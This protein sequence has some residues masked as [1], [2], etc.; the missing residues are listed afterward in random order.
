MRMLLAVFALALAA[1][2]W[3]ETAR[4]DRTEARVYVFGNSL[5][6]HVSDA[7]DPTNVPHWMNEMAKADG[8]GLSLDGQWGFLRDFADNLPPRPNWSFSGVSGA[9]SPSQGAFRDA[10]I[11]AVVLTPANFIQYQL[12]D[13]PY[14]G[15]NPTGESPLGALQRVFD[16]VE[17]NSPSSR[18]FIYEGW[19]TMDG[20]VNRFPPTDREAEAYHAHNAGEY[21][22]WYRD[23]L[24]VLEVT[25][26]DMRVTLIPVA[27][28]LAEL[29]GDGG[30]LDSL[31]A[32]ALYTDDAPHGTPTLYLLAA[33][34]TYA[35]L[36]EAP[37]PADFRPP[38]TLHP[39]VLDR[40][41]ELAAAIWERVP[42]QNAAQSVVEREIASSP[43]LP[44][45]E[46]IALPPSGMVPQGAPAL[47][48][49]LYGIS[50]WSTQHPFL[51]LMKSSR[52][53][54]GNA[55]NT[56][57]TL[58]TDE[59]RAGGYLDEND[60]PLRIPE[61]VDRIVTV[62]LTDQPEAADSLRGDYVMTYDGSGD[63]RLA[64]RAKRVRQEDGRVTFSYGPG[65][66][67]VTLS[68]TRI[69]PEDPIR[70]IVILR[71]DHIPLHE[72]GALFNP[73][74]LDRIED[75]RA[76]RFMDWMSTNGSAVSAWSDRPR[77]E[78][79]S[80]SDS[81]VPVEVM[82]RLANVIGAD[83]W[84]NMPHQADDDYVRRFASVV[85]RDLDP[86]L[87]AYV[88]YSNEV[89]NHGF[90]QAGWARAQAEALWGPSETG[91]MQFYGMR[92]AQIMDIWSAVFAADA[93]ARLVRVVATHTGW[94]GLEEQI[95]TAPLAF[96]QLGDMPVG[97]F[98]AY[99]VT[100]YFGYEIGGEEMAR[101]MDGWLDSSQELA[102]TTGEADGLQRVAL[103]EF[104]KRTR[105]DRAFQPVAEALEQGALRQLVD[106][107]F[108]YH[109]GVARKNGL[110]LIM[111][112][113]GSHLV[114][115]GARVDDERLTAFF[116]TFSY[117]PEMARLYEI[118]LAGWV[119]AGGVLF[120]AFVD[121]GP[122]TKWGSWG[123]L[124]HLDD[125]NP[126]WDML[127]AYN[128][129]GP[130]AWEDRN[131]AIFENGLRIM[132]GSGRVT[133]TPFIDYIVTGAASDVLVSGGGADVLNGGAGRDVVVLP[134]ARQSYD[135][136]RKA[137][138]TFARGPMGEVRMTGIEA[139]VFE[140][141]PELEIGTDGL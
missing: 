121:V 59:L 89:W 137:G 66:G 47:A 12:P 40:Y 88:E 17:V 60:W 18:L 79:A 5:V 63:L 65:E 51:D 64:G 30:L 54:V 73:D 97:S 11:D 128:T 101:R 98:D 34:V 123:A 33:M 86:R 119:E 111:Y 53:W 29:F 91:W 70:N 50:D 71:E 14:D 1:V 7:A 113:G 42:Q 45:R 106:E 20:I 2:L 99:A 112:E 37:P 61:E 114:G 117:T 43:P 115:Q 16:W 109:A 36:F 92:A 6:N 35:Y 95:L 76:V 25:R 127:M 9:W 3:A 131:T 108:P 120:N 140:A 80:W 116:V 90:A 32:E 27:S 87:R 96:L 104:I 93:D 100:G 21:H 136:E 19:A 130:N 72:A 58:T 26:P 139:L 38:A 94:P 124:R 125:Q 15:N 110:Q 48:V 52:G 81:G 141:E 75:M 67:V 82:V 78:L 85:K 31:P 62:V 118:L 46:A 77:M 39:E 49:G 24:N 10:G 22:Q 13:V 74:F 23:L 83:P 102:R 4:A 129:T 138:L 69:D 133:G 68:I 8:R 107:I 41:S 44:E 134:G 56:W 57:A 84:F 28:T 103:R 105:F 132:D 135:F 122:P 55:G 126:R